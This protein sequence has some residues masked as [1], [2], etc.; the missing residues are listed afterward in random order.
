MSCLTVHGGVPL[1]GTVH[2]SGSKNESLPILCA[3]LLTEKTVLKNVPHLSD[4]K[5]STDILKSFGC[6]VKWD[7]NLVI[8]SSMICDGVIPQELMCKI[9]SSILFLAPLLNRC[10]NVKF[11]RPGGCELGGRPIDFHIDALS[12]MGAKFEVDGDMIIGTCGR[13]HGGRIVLPYPSV[14]VTEAVLMAA[15][16]ADSPSVI[17]GGAKEP[18]IN[19]LG[20]FLEKSGCRIF[21]LGTDRIVV[22]PMEKATCVEFNISPDRIETATYMCMALSTGGSLYLDRADAENVENEIKALHRLGAQIKIYSDG[23]FISEKKQR[24]RVK[25]KTAPWPGFP[26]DSGPLISGLGGR[27]RKIKVKEG[28]FSNRFSYIDGLTTLGC[29][30]KIRDRFLWID[31]GGEPLG[32]AVEGKDLR[33]TASLLIAALAR[34]QETKI[35]GAEHLFRGYEDVI[36]KISDVGGNIKEEV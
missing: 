12:S 7:E 8:T 3:S 28:I 9:R 6:D 33:G 22:M 18:E 5:I 19:S 34:S 26:T 4:T 17:V 31:G 11:T 13:F 35:F 15:A 30:C 25:I 27:K 14:G 24:G 2:I 20:Y 32:T 29:R 1:R 16:V 21:G 23:I 10:G 36:K